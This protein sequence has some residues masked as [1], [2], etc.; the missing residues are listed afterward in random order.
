M[1]VKEAS[2]V[3][4]LPNKGTKKKNTAVKSVKPVDFT[5]CVTVLLL[6]ALGIIMVLSASSPAALAESGNSYKYVSKQALAAAIG[7]VLMFVISKIDYH[8][9]KPLYKM[10]YIGSFVL[11]ALVPIIGTDANG[12]KRWIDLGPLRNISTFRGCKNRINYFFCSIFRRP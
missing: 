9:Y 12:A 3:N 7:L 11:L 8:T 10:A 2:K 6:L 5:L 1:A 4:R